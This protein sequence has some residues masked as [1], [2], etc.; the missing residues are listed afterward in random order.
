M[1]VRDAFGCMY[2]MEG[3]IIL[4]PSHTFSTRI[5][6]MQVHDCTCHFEMMSVFDGEIVT[7]ITVQNVKFDSKNLQR[8]HLP[9]IFHET[10]NEYKLI[11]WH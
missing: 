2:Q 10:G 6:Y 8:E 5:A 3:K 7:R 11:T 9:I 1:R 4:V